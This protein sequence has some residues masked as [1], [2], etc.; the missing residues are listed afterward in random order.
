MVF[1]H[2]KHNSLAGTY[3]RSLQSYYH[4]LLFLLIVSYNV[5]YTF[6]VSYSITERWKTKSPMSVI[7]KLLRGT[8]GRQ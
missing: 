3:I 8:E 7:A 4:T 1:T 5:R 2:N 6:Q